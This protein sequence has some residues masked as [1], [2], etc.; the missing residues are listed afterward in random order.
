VTSN[1]SESNSYTLRMRHF[2][3]VL[4]NDNADWYLLAG[5]DWSLATLSTTGNLAPRSEQVPLSIDAQYAVGF[6]W[7]RNAQ[8]RFVKYFGKTAAVGISFESPQA[9][10]T[11]STPATTVTN[12]PGVGGGLLPSTNNYT[13]DFVPD[14]IVKL[15]A[16]PGWGHYELYGMERGFRDRYE[17]VAGSVGGTNNTAW[18]G[19]V[20]AGL[21]V[22]LTPA[23][24][25]Q[26]SGLYGNGIG[27]YGSAQLPDVTVRPNGTLAPITEGDVLLGFNIKPTSL[28]TLYVYG[29]EEAAQRKAFTS[30]TGTQYGY[31][32]AAY[33]NSGCYLLTGTA[34]TCVANTQ[35]VEQLMIGEWWKAYQG[36]IGNFQIGLQYSYTDRVAFHGVGG[37]PSTS[38]NMGFVSF[39]YYPYQR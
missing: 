25:F 12:N 27:R 18:G 14:T 3:G 7:T 39:R 28:L 16:S 4:R 15:A 13:L 31:G 6:N 5:Q 22:P 8:L 33:N 24:A 17:P 21:I 38:E 9:S 2:Y 19:S 11:G 1:S 37:A 35:H 26:A 23:I 29:G 36:V 34:S 20:G 10:F 30:S 32:N